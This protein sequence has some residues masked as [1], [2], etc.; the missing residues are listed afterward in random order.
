MTS[1]KRTIPFRVDIVGV[2]EIL[3]SALYSRPESAVRELIQNA[4][5]AIVRRRRSDLGYQGRIDIEQDRAEH[6][7]RFHDD[8]I[9]LSAEEAETYLS[10][11]GIGI[12]GLIRGRGAAA[13]VE[14]SQGTDGNL[15][16][17]FGVGLFSAF[18]LADRVVVESRKAEDGESVRWEAGPGS[19]IELSN[20][21]RERP[22]TTVTLF[23]KPEH[24]R[25]AEQPEFLEAIIKEYADFLQIP[26]HLNG[27]NARANQINSGWFDPTPDSD[28]IELELEAHFGETPLDVI[29]IR[30]DQPTAIAGALYVTT[31]RTPGFAGESVV[32]ATVRRMVIS[33][34]I[35]GLLPE[36]APFLRGVLEV[37]R[38]TPTL[39]REDL[40][41]DDAFSQVRATLEDLL[42]EHLERQA[43]EDR[44]RLESVLAWHRYTLAGAALTERRL[45]DLLRR[46]YRFPTSQGLLTFDQVI[47]RSEADPLFEAEARQVIWYNTDRRQEGWVNTLFAGYPVPCVHALRSFEE[48][49]LATM[50][51]DNTSAGEAVDL[52]LASPGSPG[53]AMA[54]LGVTELEEVSAEWQDFL[55]ADAKILSASFR[56]DRPVMAFLNERSE[57]LKTLD[58]LKK[59]EA[60]PSG[61]QRMID[62]HLGNSPVGHNEVL[63]NRDHR[64]VARALSQPTSAPLASTL[65]LLVSHAL[66]SAGASPTRT[67]LRRQADDLDWI[68]DALWGRQP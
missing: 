51:A 19:E 68:A 32:T 24:S 54:V 2:I 28:A 40:V 7:L 59:S 25:L 44:A 65:R 48:S 46:T 20:T 11:L 55:G 4:H 29:P 35:Q 22:G 58:D 43:L 27:S 64:L 5:D 23:L 15:I 49:L 21:T 57:L 33:R 18:M 9:G 52:R 31:R 39:S 8:G 34:K 38:C 60:I 41:R 56:E 16:G 12:T 37:N 63:L 36:W 45:R 26:I 6:T 47:E 17:M 61:F 66:A 42:Y 30:R 3:G 62:A 10:T 67:T 50:T 1:W 13:P 53:F 14:A